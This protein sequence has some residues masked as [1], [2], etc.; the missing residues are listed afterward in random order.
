MVGHALRILASCYAYDLFWSLKLLLLHYLE[1][2]D[3][4]HCSLWGDER[5]LVQFLVFEEFVGYLDDALLAV[6]LAGEV[7]ADCD[8]A[9]NVLQSEKVE[10]LIYILRRDVVKYSTVLQCAYY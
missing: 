8:L 6:D 1:V 3:D 7:D 9:F 2:A 4:V 10:C 5:K